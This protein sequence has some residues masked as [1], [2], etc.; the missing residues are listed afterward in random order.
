MDFIFNPEKAFSEI[1]EQWKEWHVKTNCKGYIVGI[2]GDKDSI[3][4]ATLAARIFGREQVIGLSLPNSV[5]ESRA[6]EI[7]EAYTRC[8][9]IGIS[10][11]YVSINGSF[12]S[13]IEQMEGN[14]DV[15]INLPA[16][17]RMSALF[18]YA[19]AWGYR[20]LNTCN[21][22]EDM[23]GYA[24]IF[25]D[26]AGTFS[27]ISDLTATEVIQLGKWL[28]LPDEY[29]NRTPTDGLCGLTNE[30]KLDFFY[31]Q[32]D[33]Y[34][35]NNKG[36]KSFKV[37][38]REMYEKNKFK[39]DMVRLPKVELFYPNYITGITESIKSGVGF[40]SST[41]NALK[42]LK[43]AFPEPLYTQKLEALMDFYEVNGL[44]QLSDEQILAWLN[45]Y[46][47]K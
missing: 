9:R 30:E 22:S 17:L 18:A 45:I 47:I 11:G 34:I 23:V 26:N 46:N 21:L 40:G 27:P 43:T 37:S 1:S 35:R 8:E 36:T 38:V 31:E 12:R 24:T 3:V 10:C 16:R 6:R 44:C 41:Q 19:Q 20:P 2:S 5:G 25:G 4:V 7:A 28:G 33:D 14:E 29:M 39:L 13:I 15:R 42:I 32:L